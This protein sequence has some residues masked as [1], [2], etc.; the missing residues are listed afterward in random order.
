MKT[1]NITA[2]KTANKKKTAYITKRVLLRASF[3]AVRLASTKAMRL[4]GHVVKVQ[5]GWIIR[6]NKDGTIERISKLTPK[7]KPQEIILD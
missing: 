4:A 7:V 1:S 3:K 5:D 2:K 6:E